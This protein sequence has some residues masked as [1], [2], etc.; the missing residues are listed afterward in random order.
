M[1]WTSQ[2]KYIFERNGKYRKSFL[3][4]QANSVANFAL[5]SEFNRA[6]KIATVKEHIGTKKSFDTV[7]K[8]ISM[9]LIGNGWSHTCQ[10]TRAKT[11]D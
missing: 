10:L 8:V 5:F 1:F 2:I 9:L 4:P 6:Q 11:L 7:F 3:G